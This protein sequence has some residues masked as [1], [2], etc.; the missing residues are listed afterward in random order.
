MTEQMNDFIK[1]STE[2]VQKM[3]EKQKE[4]LSNMQNNFKSQLTGIPKESLENVQS[5]INLATDLNKKIVGVVSKNPMD[6]QEMVAIMQDY[7]K[8]AMD[9]NFRIINE[10]LEGYVSKTKTKK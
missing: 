6:V 7:T 3:T 8:T 5:H 2:T 4:I 1:T 9:L 10:S